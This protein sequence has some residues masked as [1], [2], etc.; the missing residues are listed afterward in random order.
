[1]SGENFEISRRKALAAI[2]TTGIAASGAGLGTS[3]FFSDEET[4]EDNVLQAGELDLKI[5]WEEH[6]SDWS[7]D[8]SD[9]LMN[10][11]L[12]QDPQDSAYVGL[13]NPS[14]P[15]IWVHMDDLEQFMDNTAIDAYPDDDNDGSQDQDDIGNPVFPNADSICETDSDLPT[16]LDSGLRTDTEVGDPLVSITDVKP[17][18]FGELTLSF[19]LCDNPG[20]VWLRGGNFVASENGVN[21]PEADDSDEDQ[22]QGDGNPALKDPNDPEKT[23]ELLDEIQ[24]LA[25]YDED[26]DNVKDGSG[27]TPCV[28][29][30]LDASA[31]MA[32][33]RTAEAKQGA[34]D[35][36]E[37][38]VNAGGRVGVT[39]F[40]ASGVSNDIDGETVDAQNVQA[41]TNDLN[42]INT[43][44]DGLPANGGSTAIGDGI[45]AGDESLSD[46]DPATERAVQIVV[47]DGQNNTGL[48]P[49]NSRD[50]VI[51]ALDP[52]AGSDDDT[53]NTEEIFAVG[54]GDA[55]EASLQNWAY[56]VDDAH[57][58]LTNALD[59]AI[60]NLGQAVIGDECFF[61]G[62]LREFKDALTTAQGNGNVPGIPLDGNRA[63]NFNEVPGDD[64]GDEDAPSGP[65]SD[66]RECFTESSTHNI[67][68]AWYLPVDHANEIQS[69]SVEFDI[70]FYTEQC[71]HNS[72]A[73]QT[74]EA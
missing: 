71:R 20:Y 6:Y 19:H 3:A 38:V 45:W 25:W 55:S 16:A 68:I 18:D 44:I 41:L 11:I 4:F 5:D 74:P 69:D 17:G 49:A 21:E 67:G 1:M 63:T 26:G 39:Y 14:D 31:S 32:G 73:G 33:N 36:A 46:C 2:G 53:E 56:P 7:D 72:G 42:A 48:S 22:V 51:E 59:N 23:V 43:A 15:L 10:D 52:D 40:S 50:E 37:V 9:G 29:L 57:V 28:Q 64:S 35:L 34:K 60:A 70:G 66:A 24:T 61:R 13:P 30:V 65:D 62:T 58:E 54:T 27:Q 8:E 12:M 47:T